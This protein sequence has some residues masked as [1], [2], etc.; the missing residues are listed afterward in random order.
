MNHESV[1]NVSTWC[2]NLVLACR[3]LMREPLDSCN[4][5]H[6]YPIAM[7][8]GSS[9]SRVVLEPIPAT[10]VA[11]NETRRRDENQRLGSCLSGCVELDE[12]VLLGGLERGSVV[13]VSAERE[14]FGFTVREIYSRVFFISLS[15]FCGD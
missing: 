3:S 12:Y 1:P 13:G 10:I 9:I 4:N 11:E 6:P 5:H 15:C 8:A 14:E 2:A 7:E